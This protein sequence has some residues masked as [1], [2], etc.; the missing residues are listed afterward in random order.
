MVLAVCAASVAC[1][2]E[3]TAQHPLSNP[4]RTPA[5]SIILRHP[6]F[7]AAERIRQRC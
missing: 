6:H 3:T 1:A 4:E 7:D 2:R 5:A